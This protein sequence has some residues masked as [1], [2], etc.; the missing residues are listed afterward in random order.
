MKT[1]MAGILGILMIGPWGR[2]GGAPKYE[3]KHDPGREL[4]LVADGTTVWAYHFASK[5]NW[6][7]FHP[8]S[9]PG[10][11]VLTGLSPADHP[12]HRALWFSW[13]FI[14]G[15]NYW[16]FKDLKD[17]ASEPAGR[18]EFTGREDVKISAD[19]AAIAMKIDYRYA[20]AVVMREERLIRVGM[21]RADGSYAIDWRGTFIALDRDVELN[22][23]T[24]YAG[25]FFRGSPKL[26]QPRYLNSEGADAMD[27]HQKPAKWIDLTGVAD[28]DFGPAGVAIFDHPDNPRYPT[29]W[30][31]DRSRDDDEIS[32]IGSAPLFTGPYVIPAGRSMTLRYRVLVHKGAADAAALNREFEAFKSAR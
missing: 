15:V 32:Y 28:P 17:P 10:G 2:P 9:L 18:T 19:G 4:A 13:K 6:P 12:W 3:W 21:P 26:A 30:W 20:G 27:V 16:E 1:W 11:P 25:L 22:K 24:G 5:D 7:F 8:L 23:D 31:R 14:N 29:P